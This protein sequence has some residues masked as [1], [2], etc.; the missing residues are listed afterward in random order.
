MDRQK[1]TYTDNQKNAEYKPLYS[2]RL[3]ISLS[4]IIIII[5]FIKPI[6][7]SAAKQRIMPPHFVQKYSRCTLT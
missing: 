1:N 7:C 4:I 3:I 2:A 5:L 6:R